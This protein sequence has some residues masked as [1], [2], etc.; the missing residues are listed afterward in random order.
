MNKAEKPEFEKQVRSIETMSKDKSTDKCT[1]ADGVRGKGCFDYHSPAPKDKGVKPK[2]ESKQ[3]I[4]VD[5]LGGEAI[6]VISKADHK[7]ALKAKEDEIKMHSDMRRDNLDAHIECERNRIAEIGKLHEQL[8]DKDAEIASQN[9]KIEWLQDQVKELEEN[10]FK[11]QGFLLEV[12]KKLATYDSGMAQN[13]AVQH[14]AKENRKLRD[15]LYE[16]E[17]KFE[18][19]RH[20]IMLSNCA[21]LE[22]IQDLRKKLDKAREVLNW[23]ARN[24]LT[25]CSKSKAES[26]LK[27]IE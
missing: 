11:C 17:K 20:E 1:C 19:D 16:S 2:F 3:F 8:K 14:I 5:F 9:R 18:Q 21:Y 7:A 12:D 23:Y 15:D 24:T 22:Q 25:K 4:S 27:E 26:A 6:E 13:N 10:L